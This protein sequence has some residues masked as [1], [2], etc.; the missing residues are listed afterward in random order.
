MNGL[1]KIV[2][3]GNYAQFVEQLAGRILNGEFPENSSYE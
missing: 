3:H 1:E 2:P